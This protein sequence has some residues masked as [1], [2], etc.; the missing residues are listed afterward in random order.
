MVWGNGGLGGPPFPYSFLVENP[1][2]GAR[3]GDFPM[4]RVGKTMT[5]NGCSFFL[6]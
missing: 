4:G 6:F 5:L 2:P 1:I 3:L